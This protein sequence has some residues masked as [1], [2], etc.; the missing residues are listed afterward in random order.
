M[1]PDHAA[2]QEG[3]IETDSGGVIA[4]SVYSSFHDIAHLQADWDAFVEAADGD[5]YL[6][7]DWCRIWWEFYGTRRQLRLYLFYKEGRLVGLIPTFHETQ[8]IGPVWL[9]IAKLIG[10]D[11]PPCMVNPPVR[12]DLAAAMFRCVIE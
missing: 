6:T 10:S 1:T 11:S 3:S 7:F 5:I 8:W 9:T 2:T 4:Y 12:L